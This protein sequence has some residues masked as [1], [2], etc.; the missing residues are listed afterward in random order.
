MADECD[1]EIIE[2]SIV[3][4]VDSI[5]EILESEINVYHDNA[6]AL[7]LA[8]V[9]TNDPESIKFLENATFSTDINLLYS[10]LTRSTRISHKYKFNYTQL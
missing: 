1:P 7:L 6:F 2:R 10:S 3:S 5:L 4:N 9:G 8:L